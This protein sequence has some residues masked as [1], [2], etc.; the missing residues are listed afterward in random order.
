MGRGDALDLFERSGF[1]IALD[2]DDDFLAA[3]ARGDEAAR[4]R[5]AADPTLVARLQAED[6]G[7]L[8]RFAGAGN[9]AA[10]RLLIDLGFDVV[11]P[12]AGG[13]TALHLATWRGRGDTVRLLLHRGAPL[14]AEDVHGNTPLALA[15]RALVEWSE[16]TP[17]D[18]TV[19]VE[20]LLDAGADPRPVKLA[21]GLPEVDEM[22]GRES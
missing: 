17:H 7:I 11:R 13:Q 5:V 9:T 1:G 4:Y 10:V 20:A 8:S 19:I 18:T 15:V 16:W 12:G 21:S 2:R 3:C 22:L 14:E 6:G